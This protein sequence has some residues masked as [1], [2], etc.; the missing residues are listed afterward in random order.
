MKHPNGT[1]DH[2]GM[3]PASEGYLTLMR[4]LDLSPKDQEWWDDNNTSGAAQL[5]ESDIAIVSGEVR[6][7]LHVIEDTHNSPIEHLGISY[8]S[9]LG[10]HDA[11]QLEK[12][13]AQL[14]LPE[15]IDL[16]SGPRDFMAITAYTSGLCSFGTATPR[17]NCGQA[18]DSTYRAIAAIVYDNFALS[19]SIYYTVLSQYLA[20]TGSFIDTELGGKALDGVQGN[21]TDHWTYV[22]EAI[23]SFILREKESRDLWGARIKQIVLVGEMGND[24]AFRAALRTAL[25]STLGGVADPEE[26]ELID[27]LFVAAMGAARFTKDLMDAPKPFQCSESTECDRRRR[28]AMQQVLER[29]HREIQRREL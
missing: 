1:L 18:G 23:A 26:G 6:K 25:E 3:V 11:K 14:G 22:T 12:A 2:I 15:G 9:F 19:A 8:P 13:T 7:I 10:V 21:A 4:G 16:Q 29:D 24:L 28:K 27:P 20:P 17:I 5:N